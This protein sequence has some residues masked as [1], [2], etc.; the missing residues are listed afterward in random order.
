MQGGS[1]GATRHTAPLWRA[2]LVVSVVAGTAAAEPVPDACRVL[3]AEADSRSSLLYAPRVEVHGLHSPQLSDPT[4]TALLPS[5]G[6]QLRAGLAFSPLDVVRG[7]T[8]T[9][10][11]EAECERLL[12]REA[13]EKVL[14]QG[15]SFGRPAALKVQVTALEGGLARADEIVSL[16][17]QRLER[18][19]ATVLDV[20]ELRLRRLS[21]DLRLAEL[22]NELG[23]LGEVVDESDA[24]RPWL[25]RYEVASVAAHEDHALLR[26]LDA[27]QVN[28]Q[29]GASPYPRTDWFGVVSL[30]WNVGALA[31]GSAEVTALAARKDELRA[32]DTELRARVVRFTDAMAESAR[33]LRTELALIDRQVATYRGRLE[34]DRVVSE[35]LRQSLALLEMDLIELVA[36]RA[37]VERL[38]DARAK[39]GAPG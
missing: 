6:Y 28:L 19:V 35:R 36:R 7:R 32:G 11:A 3:R 16:A 31:Q 33:L 15:A 23:L 4:G 22:R 1:K 39:V 27:W 38:L 21:I 5:G 17:D 34:T 2:L 29:A 8:V 10:T 9:S 30:G 26:R 24:V 12:A 20:E 25:E 14:Q 37:F 18:G 13:L